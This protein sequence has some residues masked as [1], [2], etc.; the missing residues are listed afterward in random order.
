MDIG[1]RPLTRRDIPTWADL[2]EEIERV[3]RTGEHFSADDLAEEM[4]NPAV[5][6]GKDF[7]GAFD[8]AGQMVGYFSVLP[9]GAADG[10]YAIDM[11]GSVLPGRRAQGVGTLLVTEMVER[12]TRARDERRPDLPAR[13]FVAGLSSDLSQADLLASAGMRG[14]RWTFLMRTAL[15]ALQPARPLAAGYRLRSYDGSMGDA[16]RLAHNAAFLDHPDFTPWS[17]GLW[18][19][20]VTESR[21]FRPD[22]SFVVSPDDSEAIVAYLQTAEFEADLAATGRRE[23]YVGKV[24]TLRAHRGKGLA[25]GLLGHA[26]HAYR[27]AGYD[28]ATLAVDSENPTGALGVYQRV[29]FTVESR[30]TNYVM[31]VGAPA[32]S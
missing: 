28:E 26:L 21:S 6:V 18:K 3:D 22:V 12:A 29:G 32:S 20:S 30:W 9:R 1:L 8:P 5:E 13:L 24:G 14:E 16:L 31:T 15:D 17:E 27:E 25:T 2:R 19:Q 7:V 10:H 11:Q 4:A 23:A